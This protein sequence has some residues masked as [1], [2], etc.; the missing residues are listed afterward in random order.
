MSN[1]NIE[2]NLNAYNKLG[3]L[4]LLSNNIETAN[5]GLSSF[6]EKVGSMFI[7]KMESV[8]EVLGISSKQAN[9][10]ANDFNSFV[11]DLT[12]NREQLL[13]VVNNISYSI[14]NKARVMAPVGLKVDLIKACDELEDSIKLFTNTA[15]KSLLELDVLVSSILNDVNFR[16]QTKPLKPNDAP[17]KCGDKLYSVLNRLVDTRKV[18]DTKIVNELI[19]NLS[20]LTKLYDNL[21]KSSELTSVNTLKEINEQIDNIY[22]KT[23]VLAKEMEGDYTV[24][25]TVLKKLSADLES[26]A[27]MVTVIM[28]TIYLYNQIV[29]CVNNMV[30]KFVNMK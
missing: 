26:N 20:C 24:S 8:R 18:E 29:L 23:E 27:K 22:V 10:V 16:T 28:S 13:W 14:V 1:I 7:N 15:V 6:L 30:N 19:P 25:K 12:K 21:I 3:T 4:T 5:E 17:V 9:A 2:Q 11:A